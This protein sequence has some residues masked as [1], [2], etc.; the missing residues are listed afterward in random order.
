MSDKEKGSITAVILITS[1]LSSCQSPPTFEPFQEQKQR[2]NNTMKQQELSD[3]S[4]LQET[5]SGLKYIQLSEGTSQEKPKMGNT[6]TV[7]YTGWLYDETAPDHKGQLFDSS[8]K[9]NQ[10][11]SF[12]LGLGH[13]IQGWDEGV[14][15][16][17]K[18]SSYRLIIPPHLGYGSMGA[19]N[20]IPPH[21]TLVFDVD[22]I[23][24]K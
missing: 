18:G 4:S 14:A 15:K 10:P 20:S 6:V 16:M 11:F 3:P 22:L 7:H 21:A 1:L 19:G 9:R 24:F 5:A 8:H 17:T 13:V 2:N 12:R 23:D